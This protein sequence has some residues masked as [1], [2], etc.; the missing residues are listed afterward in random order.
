[1]EL[2]YE[3]RG[4]TSLAG[5]SSMGNHFPLLPDSAA[6]YTLFDRHGLPIE[7]PVCRANTRWHPHGERAAGASLAFVC[8]HPTRSAALCLDGRSAA[9][10]LDERDPAA[11]WLTPLGWIVARAPWYACAPA[12]DPATSAA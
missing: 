4:G 8:R 2:C 12:D 6:N 3:P 7:C 10:L 9:L 1:M 5:A 11:A